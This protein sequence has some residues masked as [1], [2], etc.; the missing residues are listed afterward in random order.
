M[1][2]LREVRTI[3]QDTLQ[4]AIPSLN[5]YRTAVD[6]VNS[7][8]VMIAPDTPG[9][10]YTQNMRMKSVEWR[11]KLT[12]LVAWNDPTNSQ[13]DLDDLLDATLSGSIPRA[14]FDARHSLPFPCVVEQMTQYGARYTFGTQEY[15]GAVIRVRVIAEGS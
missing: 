14:L 9:A 1:T 2:T 6:A 13:D 7:P 4:S 3:L 8:A 15:V 11:I 5:V 12:V 10:D